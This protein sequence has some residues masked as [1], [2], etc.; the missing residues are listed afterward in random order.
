MLERKI[1]V[2]KLQINKSSIEQNKLKAPSI[3]IDKQA[4]VFRFAELNIRFGKMVIQRE[5]TEVVRYT[6]TG[7]KIDDIHQHKQSFHRQEKTS[8]LLIDVVLP[9][10]KISYKKKR[11]VLSL[12][13]DLILKC[14][15]IALHISEPSFRVIVNVQES[16]I[17]IY[18]RGG[19]LGNAAFLFREFT[20]V[21][22]Q[23]SKLVK[24]ATQR[25]QAQE[26]IL[27]LFA[28]IA[29]ESIGMVDSLLTQQKKEI[30]EE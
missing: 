25:E 17:V 12:L 29:E 28:N 6:K 15:E 8:G 3:Q 4:R 23:M 24:A 7:N 10:K 5:T 22:K 11:E 2:E 21:A 14:T 16:K 1:I 30:I 18:D 13:K 26:P 9:A 20:K 27:P 19:E